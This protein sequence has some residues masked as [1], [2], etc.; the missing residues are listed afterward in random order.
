MTETYLWLTVAVIALVTAA[1]RFLPFLLSK[2]GQATPKLV[3]KLGRLLPF[4]VLGMLVVYCL[5]DVQFHSLS[6]FL[7]ALIASVIVCGSYIWK[8]NTLVSIISGTL[9]YMVLVQFVF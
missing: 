5:K 9:S 3:E 4:A 2:N 8:R 7:P 1:I 6:G